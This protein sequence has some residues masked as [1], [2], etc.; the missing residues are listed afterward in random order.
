MFP[1]RNVGG[2][3]GAVTITDGEINDLAVMFCRA[4][5]QIEIAE[6]VEV[7][8]VGAVGRD[9]FVVFAPHH[10]RAAKGI[11]DGLAQHP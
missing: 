11:F 5:D 4:E 7:A 6:G 8:K 2:A 3:I 9:F 1:A 10:F